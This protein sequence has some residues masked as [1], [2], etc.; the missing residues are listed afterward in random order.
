[1]LHVANYLASSSDQTHVSVQVQ[2][3]SAKSGGE[4]SPHCTADSVPHHHQDVQHC[5]HYHD[6]VC[7]SANGDDKLQ[8]ELAKWLR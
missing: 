3:Y 1:M 4:E 7:P 8:L 2:C 5:L 6:D